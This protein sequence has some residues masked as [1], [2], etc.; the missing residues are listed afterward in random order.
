M[1]A[2]GWR[3]R[4]GACRFPSAGQDLREGGRMEPEQPTHHFSCHLRFLAQAGPAQ[5]LVTGR[6]VLDGES[7][8]EVLQVVGTLFLVS[9]FWKVFQPTQDQVVPLS[10]NRIRDTVC[11]ATF[12]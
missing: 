11:S 3:L 5:E 7:A 1:A 8:Q 6:E 12:L 4:G 10:N 9:V 2:N